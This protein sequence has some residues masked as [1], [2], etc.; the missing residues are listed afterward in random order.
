MKQ[1]WL[2]YFRNLPVIN[3]RASQPEATNVTRKLIATPRAGGIVC[4]LSATAFAQAGRD[5]S[6][7][8]G[9]STVYPF[10]STLAE[11]FGRAGKFKTPKVESTG[12]GCGLK[13]FCNG[14][15]PQF[16]DIAN[17]SRR[18]KPAELET[19]AQNGVKEVGRIEV[20]CA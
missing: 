15:G 6:N 4:A 12:T 2:K 11:Q 1:V 10:T 8:V 9:S 16:P 14:V 19:C 13:L 20:R 5:A 3:C 17:A 18:I 7:I